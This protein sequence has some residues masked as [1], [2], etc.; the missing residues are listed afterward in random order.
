MNFWDTSDTFDFEKNKADLINNLDYLT[1]MSV[2]EQTLYKKWIELNEKLTDKIK[3]LPM[4]NALKEQIWQPSNIMDK[5]TTIKEIE[6]LEPYVELAEDIQKWT[7]IR[8]LISTM[9]FTANPGRNVKAY[10]KD[11]VSN[12]ILGVISLGSDI[13]CVAV[14]DKYIGWS[15]DNKFKEGKLNNTTIGT[16]IIPTQPLGYNF[17]GGKLV[18]ALTTSP[19][20]R[21]EW[22]DKY[23]DTLIAV[24][25]TALY[26]ASSQYNGIPH[27]KTLGE[28]A[29][30]M[31]TKPDNWIYKIWSN[32]LK[33]NY[34]E[35]YKKAI[36]GTA[37]KQRILAL[38]W[39]K[40]GI[41]HTIYHHGFKRG[42]YLAQIYENGND[43]LCSKINEAE[44][45][46]KPKFEQ[47]D[48]YTIKWWKDKA[49]KR[50]T[51]L[52]NDNRIKNETLYYTDIIG[53]TWEQC[54]G[55]YLQDV[56]R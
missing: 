24:G 33:K 56:G 19:V 7:Y 14:R 55:K 50:Y 11:R 36:S 44:L 27:F 21:K 23:N 10:V 9:E 20:F 35:E 2:Q 12:K 26:G 51:T 4:F 37:P 52:Y 40:L 28:S 31:G 45:Q 54:K 5:D 30:K 48:A 13:A 38:L 1:N 22:K 43:Y 46:M 39:R 29:G 6:E 41:N 17:L 3:L 49:I 15:K 16:S 34:V 25:T 32:Y 18:A 8:K 47:G 42:V 53:M